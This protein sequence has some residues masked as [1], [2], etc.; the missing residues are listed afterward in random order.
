[1][2]LEQEVVDVFHA[3]RKFWSTPELVE[4]LLFHLPLASTKELA[5]C[6]RLT[7]Q[8]LGKPFCWNKLSNKTLEGEDILNLSSYTFPREDDMHLA[9]M[10]P[11][12]KILTEILNLAESADKPQLELDFLHTICERYLTE[13]MSQD[14][15]WPP[16]EMDPLAAWVETDQGKKPRRNHVSLSCCCLETHQLSPWGFVLLMDVEATLVS[17]EQSIEEVVVVPYFPDLRGPLLTALAS[18]VVH[19]QEM[20]KNL[21]IGPV[22]CSNKEDA[23]NFATLVE[24]CQEEALQGWFET[25]IVVHNIGPEGWAA[26]RRGVECLAAARPRKISVNCGRESLKAG[27]KEDMKAIWFAI[28]EEMVYSG[29]E[30]VLRFDKE[31]VG[32]LGG[33]MGFEGL[34]GGQRKGLDAV[35]DMT[36]EEFL[37]EVRYVE[38]LDNYES[39]TE[40]EEEDEEEEEEAGEEEEEEEGD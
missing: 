32:D 3:E 10:R 35:I 8:I 20:V 13:D 17:R 26:V 6:H 36:E 30:G 12:I 9:A 25:M 28:Q 22:C 14:S 23:E 11:K 21:D 31:F 39:S 4:K 40:E 27:R 24:H 2:P 15:D 18:K 16:P 34:K 1:M 29:D 33:W 38:E 19:Q 37:K 7:R 5:R